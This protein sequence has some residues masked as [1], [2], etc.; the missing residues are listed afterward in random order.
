MPD[1]PSSRVEDYRVVLMAPG[2]DGL[3]RVIVGGQAVNVWAE[4]YLAA[5]P[6][7]ADYLP[8]TSKDLDLLGDAHD[9]DRLAVLTGWRKRAALRRVFIPSAGALEMPRDGQPPVKIE[10]LKRIYG[11]ATED[12]LR[13][14]VLVERSGLRLR[15]ID[16]ITLLQAK[17]ENAVKL[18]QANRQDVKH[19][20][21][22]M[23]CVRAF[24][25]EQLAEIEA[26]RLAP[27]DYVDALERVL[28]VASSHTA[29]TA[30]RKLGIDWMETLPLKELQESPHA[31]LRNFVEKRLPRWVADRQK[32]QRKR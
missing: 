12:V 1:T 18:P 22:M 5:E 16:P 3:P 24:L 7:L 21:M 29:A 17:T 14:A 8:F 23:L 26:G 19:M 28:Q 15:V 13:T 25:G 31:K 11:I 10:I 9:L 2:P 4:R 6:R 27:R 30:A 32:H 20:R